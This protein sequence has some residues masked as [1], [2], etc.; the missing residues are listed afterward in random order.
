[1]L[2]FASYI[3]PQFFSFSSSRVGKVWSKFKYTSFEYLLLLLKLLTDCDN[4]TWK[5]DKERHHHSHYTVITKTWDICIILQVFYQSPHCKTRKWK[6]NPSS[7]TQSW[8]LPAVQWKQNPNSYP[9]DFHIISLFLKF[10][11]NWYTKKKNTETYIESN[12]TMWEKQSS[13]HC[14]Y[15]CGASPEVGV[16]L[17]N[18]KSS[19]FYTCTL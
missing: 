19:R 1:M 15:T 3:F 8:D 18:P 14:S 6:M 17:L 7:D 2:S 13:L 10:P 5:R 16:I 11:Q 9:F 12:I 4:E